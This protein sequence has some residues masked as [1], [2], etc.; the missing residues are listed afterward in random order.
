MGVIQNPSALPRMVT[1]KQAVNETGLTY[2][3][4]R[5]LCINGTLLHVRSGR[6]YYINADS[7]SKYL[8]NS[9]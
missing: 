2:H 7:L 8:N 5:K 3:F 6:H 1:I 9:Y 4:L